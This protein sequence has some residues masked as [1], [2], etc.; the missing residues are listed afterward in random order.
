MTPEEMANHLIH[1]YIPDAAGNNRHERT[2]S[3]KNMV[4]VTAQSI[5]KQVRGDRDSHPKVLHFWHDVLLIAK[6]L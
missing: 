6:E 3:A 1:C 4:I 2:A 5:L